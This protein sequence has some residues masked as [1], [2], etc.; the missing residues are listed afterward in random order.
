MQ[1]RILIIED[2]PDIG[3]LLHLHIAGNGREVRLESHGTR[4]LMLAQAR[5]W[6][7]L[8]LDWLLPGTDGVTICRRLRAEG[9]SLP[10]LLL[11]A[12]ASEVDRVRGLDAGADDYVAKPFSVLELKARVR[13]QLRRGCAGHAESVAAVDLAPLQQGPLRIDPASRIVSL[14][15]AALDLTAR[16]FDLLFY[17]ATHPGRVFT[18]QQLLSAV[19]GAGFEG[20]EH[21]VNSHINRLR[22]KLEPH[23]DAKSFIT[24][25]WGTG[26]RYDADRMQ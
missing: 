18:R 23:A 7:L 1:Q 3:A 6:D 20:Y 15:E 14:D 19:W 16:E 9:R 10:I 22:A 8:V 11:T 25:V 2:D 12:R 21:T 17:F 13:A 26:Y 5:R 24:T 4:G